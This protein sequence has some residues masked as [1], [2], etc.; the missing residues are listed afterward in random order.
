MAVEKVM[1]DEVARE[2]RLAGW[3]AAQ[4]WIILYGCFAAQMI[5]CVLLFVYLARRITQPQ[6]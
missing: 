4:E 3:E 6:Q 2:Y 5:F 1:V